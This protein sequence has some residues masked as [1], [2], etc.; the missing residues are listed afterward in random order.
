MIMVNILLDIV[1][2]LANLALK[3]KCQ[4]TSSLHSQY[5]VYVSEPLSTPYYIVLRKP[6]R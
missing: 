6:P 5:L 1:R 3:V 2:L 4:L